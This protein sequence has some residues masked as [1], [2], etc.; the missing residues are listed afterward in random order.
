MQP[1]LD[2]PL[3]DAAKTHVRFQM[4]ILA[5]KLAMPS[6]RPNMVARP[7]LTARLAQSG[8]HRLMVVIAPAGWGKSSLVS[9]W[10]RQTEED[11][12]RVAWVSLDAGDNDPVRF[13]LYLIAALNTVSP[14]VGE[15]AGNLLH[16]LQNPSLDTAL[17]VL[18]NDLHALEQTV[19]LVLDDYHTIEAQAVHHALTFLVEHLPPTLRLV[20]ATR[21]DPPLPLSRLRVRGSWS[22][23]APLIYALSARKSRHS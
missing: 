22:N 16:T 15:M 4:P 2:A 7:R 10:C 20:I 21:V 14:G 18:L 11:A 13:L 23:C 6:A 1:I 12:R 5:T 19:T 3:T 9:Q 17:T 8:H